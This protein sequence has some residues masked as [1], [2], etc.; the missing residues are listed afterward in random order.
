VTIQVLKAA[1]IKMAVF[2]VVALCSLE[3]LTDVPEVLAASINTRLHGA[4]TINTVIFLLA[5]VRT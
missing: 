5:A 1:S 2:S 3:K 4:T